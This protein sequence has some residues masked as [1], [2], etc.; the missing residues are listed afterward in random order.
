MHDFVT[1]CWV[2]VIVA[3]MAFMLLWVGAILFAI[4]V[5]ILGGIFSVL[6]EV[7]QWL[8]GGGDPLLPPDQDHFSA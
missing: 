1:V 3:A 5:D 4:A 2:I 7:W 6:R 8:R